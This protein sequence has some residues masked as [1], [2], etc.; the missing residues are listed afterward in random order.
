MPSQGSFTVNTLSRINSPSGHFFQDTFTCAIYITNY[1]LSKHLQIQDTFIIHNTFKW[2][3]YNNPSFVVVFD[4]FRF[5]F[6]LSHIH[7]YVIPFKINL[8]GPFILPIIGF[9]STFKSCH[10]LKTHSH[11]R[12]IPN[13]IYITSYWL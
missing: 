5:S 13:A 2:A 1:W 12:W 8:N 3:N 4:T 10:N 7:L 6:K 9:H 11:L